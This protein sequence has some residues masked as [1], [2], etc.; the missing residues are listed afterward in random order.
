MKQKLMKHFIRNKYPQDKF[1][2][3]FK[4]INFEDFKSSRKV[5]N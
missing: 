1:L 4:N 3:I 2:N 5:E